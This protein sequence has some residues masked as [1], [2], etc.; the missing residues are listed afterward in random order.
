MHVHGI[1]PRDIRS[2]LGVRS[3][4][5]VLRYINGERVPAPEIMAA[6]HELT[7]GAVT[8][9]DFI[10]PKPPKCRRVVIDRYGE[11]HEIYPWTVLEHTHRRENANDNTR[12]GVTPRTRQAARNDN[13][14]R[15]PLATPGEDW[16]SAP[17]Q[18]ALTVLGGRA[19]LARKGGFLLDGR[20]ADSKR[21]VAAANRRLRELGQPPIP[22]PGLE[23]PE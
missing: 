8:L 21:V 6:I 11:P 3:R 15:S 20:I 23:S 18:R 14:P 22:Y 2:M 4:T 10:D 17:L 13:D 5:T 16:P 7:G 12:D 19:M 1:N 9:A